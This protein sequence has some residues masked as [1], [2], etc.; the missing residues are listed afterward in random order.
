MF[1]S[2]SLETFKYI[3]LSVRQI[4]RS[5]Q[6]IFSTMLIKFVVWFNFLLIIL[7]IQ[8]A[9]LNLNR[10]KSSGKNK[11]LDINVE[12]S[13]LWCATRADIASNNLTA[14]GKVATLC[15]PLCRI[16]SEGNSLDYYCW[17]WFSR[18]RSLCSTWKYHFRFKYMQAAV[19]DVVFP[20]LTTAFEIVK[21]VDFLNLLQVPGSNDGEHIFLGGRLAASHLDSADLWRNGESNAPKH[22]KLLVNKIWRVHQLAVKVQGGEMCRFDGWLLFPCTSYCN[23][24]IMFSCTIKPRA[25]QTHFVFVCLISVTPPGQAH[26]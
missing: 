15:S 19:Y 5:V 12:L 20:A 24:F 16:I 7:S 1:Y 8:W 25:S 2:T 9:V 23:V 22:G 11:M 18:R 4:Y 10:V 21:S 13:L 26:P 3:Y 6:V 17:C 14:T